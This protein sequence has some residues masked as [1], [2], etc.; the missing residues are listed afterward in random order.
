MK[1]LN[2]WSGF[3]PLAGA[4]LVAGCGGGAEAE[5]EGGDEVSESGAGIDRVVLGPEALASLDLEYARAEVRMLAPSLEAPAEIMP[6]PDQHATIG[7]RVAGRVSSVSV[8]VG[9]DV[10][11]AA[12]LVVMESAEVGRAAADY[13]GAEAELGV[14]RQAVERARRLFEQ[15]ISSQQALERAEAEFAADEANLRAAEARLRAFGVPPGGVADAAEGRV[16]LKSP[17]AGTVS[18]RA[19]H[20]G[21]WVEPSEVIIELVGLDSLWL[22]ASV[23]ER[24]LRYISL[25][26]RVQIEVRAYPGEVF[27]CVVRA[28]ESTLD[29]QTRSARVRVTL[30][31]PDHRLKPGMFATARILGTHAHDAREL[32]AVPISAVEEI[33]GHSAVFVRVDEGVFE[34]RT[35]HLGEQDGGFVEVLNGLEAGVDV[36]AD[37]SFMLKGQLLRSTLGEDE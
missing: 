21:Q 33:E 9:D 11:R 1:R 28:I 37:G 17:I 23:Y 22:I 5:L 34:V 16:T 14:S 20:V 25:G 4:L 10:A 7:P 18:A 19:A 27:E 36:V 13:I 24:D 12:P 3:L 6:I 30:A 15:R 31:N 26:Q 32:L 2:R 35:V 29:E 8:N